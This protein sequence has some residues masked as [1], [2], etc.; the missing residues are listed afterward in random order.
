MTV[1]QTVKNQN[2]ILQ[3]RRIKVLPQGQLSRIIGAESRVLD[4]SNRQL[5]AE[6]YA[7]V[8]APWVRNPRGGP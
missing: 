3:D 1:L 4:G 2:R 8:T 5:T 7:T 6:Q